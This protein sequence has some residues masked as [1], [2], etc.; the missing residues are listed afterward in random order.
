MS[1][2]LISN[3]TTQDLSLDSAAS[4]FLTFDLTSFSLTPFGLTPLGLTPLDLTSF[5]LTPFGLT[6]VGLTPLDL[7]SFGLTPFGLTSVSLTPLDLTSFFSLTSLDL[8]CD[9]T[10]EVPEDVGGG[11]DL[12][13]AM[14]SSSIFCAGKRKHRHV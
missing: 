13:L 7:T 14:A 6:S 11:K 1:S 8:T 5:G 4:S 9:L 2:L 10:P 3:F 12:T